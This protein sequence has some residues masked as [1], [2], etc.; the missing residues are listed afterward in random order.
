MEYILAVVILASALIQGGFYPAI[1]LGAAIV[2]V[3]LTLFCANKKLDRC[4][5]TIWILSGLFLITSLTRGYSSRSLS[6]ACIPGICAIFLYLYR[7]LSKEKKSRMLRIVLAGSGVLAGIS[8][9]TFCGIFA[10]EGAVSSHRLQFPFQYANAAGS[11]FAVSAILSQDSKE[12]RRFLLP[13]LAALFL[14]RSIGAFGF[15][16]IIQVIQLWWHRKDGLWRDTLLSH[17]IAAG[18]AVAFFYLKGWLAVLLLILLYIVGYRQKNIFSMAEKL[19]FHWIALLAGGIGVAAL[20]F[21]QRFASSLRSLAERLVQVLD[22]L[23]IVAEHPLLGIGAGN[24]ETWYPHYQS[25]QYTSTVIHS[26]I[27]Q[28]GVDAGVLAIAMTG[29]FV[30]FAWRRGKSNRAAAGFLILHSLLDFTMQFLPIS[31]LL[32]A[33]LFSKEDSQDNQF[34]VKKNRLLPL[35]MGLICTWCLCSQITYK[36]LAYNMQRQNWTAVTEK[37]ERQHFLLGADPMSHSV[38]LQALYAQG[39]L[40][41]ILE[42]MDGE[43]HPRLEEIVFYVRAIREIGGEDRACKMLLGELDRQIYQVSLFEQVAALFREWGVDKEWQDAYNQLADKANN[44]KSTLGTLKGDQVYINHI[45][46]V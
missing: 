43:E 23:R 29:L 1:F 14:T 24:W 19:Y 18:S 4:D 5:W 42:T 17:S 33:T 36:Q 3:P 25:T 37:Y 2:L 22:A 6:Q 30:F 9:L 26:S 31:L 28:I 45:N 10:I 16:G 34:G 40:Q 27:A 8:V 39:N 11:W 21:S 20:L 46:I 12:D 38:Y 32:M 35:A 13:I 44:A 7:T 41:G 15:Y